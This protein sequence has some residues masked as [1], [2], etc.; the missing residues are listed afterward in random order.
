M[1][2]MK[3]RIVFTPPNQGGLRSR[4]LLTLLGVLFSVPLHIPAAPP[5]KTE[6]I[7]I[8]SGLSGLT[9]A[10]EL[11]KAKIPYHV[12]EL[13]P[14]VGGR[15]RTVTYKVKGQ[16]DI[17]VD[18]GMEEYWQSNPAVQVIKELGLPHSEGGAFSTMVLE[19]ELRINLES[20]SEFL[21]KIFT[22]EEYQ[23]LHDFNV[24]IAPWIKEMRSGAPLSP[25]LLKLKDIAFSDFLDRR[26]KLDSKVKNWIRISIEC[27]IGTHYDR[28]SALDGLDEFAIFMWDGERSYR[29]TGGNEN[30]VRALG[31]AVGP[32]NISLNHRVTQIVTTSDHNVEVQ[33][34]SAESNENGIIRG[35]YVICTIPLYRL[36]EVQFVPPLSEKK[37]VAIRTQEW[38]S[39][40]KTHIFLPAKS[41]R[42]WTTTNGESMLPILSDSD[43]GVIYDGNPGQSEPTK[44]LSL[45]THGD[46]AESFN[47]LTQDQVRARLLEKLD[48]FWPGIASEVTRL[49]FYRFHPRAIAAWP[50]GRSRFDKLSN[51]IRMPENSVYLAGD[52]TESSHSSGATKSAH[53]V[54]QQILADRVKK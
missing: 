3:L 40:F 21:K 19:N 50:V 53:R 12:L 16:P 47:M 25:E 44:V 32:K 23:S 49:E 29:V 27:E 18:S 43:L 51:E 46:T 45:L 35:R 24:M 1:K 7:I 34:L 2:R 11:K 33:Y 8:G 15:V 6:V 52:F 39:Y 10:Y 28:I 5:E 26:T 38:G 31:K 22:P 36:F 42:Y 14:R 48:K 37:Q 17:R 9:A 4:V 30:F 41:A 20:P 54:V 13:T